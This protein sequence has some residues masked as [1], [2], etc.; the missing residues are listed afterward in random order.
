MIGPYFN[1]GTLALIRTVHLLMAYF[2]IIEVTIHVGIIEL[3][4]KI[5]KFH[6]AIFWTGKSDLCDYHYVDLVNV[7]DETQPE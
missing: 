6:K 1:L 3:D 4:P 5:W 2:F 7:D